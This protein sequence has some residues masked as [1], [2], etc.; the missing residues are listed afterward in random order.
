MSNYFEN[1]SWK[2]QRL[3]KFTSSEIS[4]LL[5]GGRKKDQLFGLTAL[6]YIN[7]K[8]AEIITGESKVVEGKALEWGAANESDG[9][10]LFQQIHHEG[11][12]YF[13]VAN[14]QFFP[15]TSIA[16]GSPDGLT[17]T[18]VIEVK[19]PYNS[20]NHVEFLLAAKG[21]DHN[22]W[23]AENREDYY[24]QVQMNMLCTGR[25]KAYLISYDPR[26]INH[27]H[28]IAVLEID[29]DKS[30]QDDLVIRLSEAKNIVKQALSTL[31]DTIDVD[32][33]VGNQGL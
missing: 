17:E 5:K 15:F 33:I 19:C 1:S 31:E 23:L 29:I 16:G 25:A 13:G 20:A 30:L 14:P 11:I 6:S 10:N 26:A 18:A 32:R 4:K 2:E 21:S 9:I 12:E 7:E 24:A 28:R 22:T 27:Y 3:G 8:I